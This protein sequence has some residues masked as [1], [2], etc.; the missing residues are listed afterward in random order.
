LQLVLGPFDQPVDDRLAALEPVRALGLAAE[1]L[2]ADRLFDLVQALDLLQTRV[3]R[4]RLIVAGL[5]ELAPG[6]CPACDRLSLE[7]ENDM[8]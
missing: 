4:S 2:F 5:E 8:T 3:D 1:R 7:K 6:M